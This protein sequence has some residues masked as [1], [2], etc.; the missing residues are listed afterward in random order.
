MSRREKGVQLH[1]TI[2]KETYK[3]IK[4]TWG[5]FADFNITK[6]KQA[7]WILDAFGPL[8]P[9]ALNDEATYVLHC[10]RESAPRWI[11]N[12]KTAARGG[13]AKREEPPRKEFG[14]TIVGPWRGSGTSAAS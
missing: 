7:A 12:F 11:E 5:H 1:V 6:A 3:A 2:P 14:K 8:I 13:I 10:F 4:T 9:C